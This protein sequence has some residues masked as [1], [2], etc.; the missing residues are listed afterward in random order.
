M[1]DPIRKTVTVP[2]RP[3]EAF[4][5][6]TRDLFHWWPMDTH[7]LSAAKGALPTAVTVEPREGGQIMETLPDGSTAP[8][9]RVTTWDRGR[10]FGVL[11]HVGRDEAQATDLDL[12]FTPTDTGTR[13]D[14]THG[15]FDR[16][17]KEATAM[18]ENYTTGWDHVLG[19]CYGGHCRA[20][21]SA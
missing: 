12:V 14:L 5:V 8:W 21:V 2:L 18:A 1:T 9:G 3:D 17:G 13:V 6:F 20:R 7:S 4:D 19:A 11:W 10:A 15:G 16:L